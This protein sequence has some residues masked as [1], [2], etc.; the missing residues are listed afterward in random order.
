MFPFP[1]FLPMDVAQQGSVTIRAEERHRRGSDIKTF[2]SELNPILKYDVIWNGGQN[3]LVA[4]YQPRFIYTSTYDRRFPPENL[5]NRG[6]LNL[7]DPNDTPLSGYHNGGFGYEVTRQRWRLSLY[8]F[9]AYGDISTT[10]LLV[11]APWSGEGPPP[12]PFPIIPSTIGA[13]FTLLFLQTQLF[14]PVRL[15]PRTALIPG[16]T[17]N[18][19]GGAD[20]ASRGVIALTRGPGASLALDHAA[21]RR[22]RLI[23]SVAAF[24]V[25]T[26]F[27]DER[28]SIT[29]V[30]AEATQAW[31][32]YFD[33]HLTGEV[34]GGASIG[35]DRVNGFSVFSLGSM[36]L[37][38]D[39]WPTPRIPP[40]AAPYGLVGG[41]GNRL[42]LGV[43]A[44]VVPWID[45]FS[46][47]LEQRFVTSAAANYTIDRV[48]LRAG[49]SQARVINT[50]RSVAEY[51]IVLAEGSV[52]VRLSP[53]FSADGGVRLGYQ[54]FN[55]AVRFNELTQATIYAGLLWAPLPARF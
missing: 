11:Q 35:G 19:F 29:I 10:A 37:L 34:S 38:W 46:G 9:G 15:S 32:H 54:S 51:Q 3:H 41:H 2:E 44:K 45:L 28:D 27:Q 16:A 39:S 30:R 1:A 53:T 6:T 26:E 22:D 48:T 36:S 25:D 4:I 50:P 8:Q 12:D 33:N 49:L 43:V 20:R 18:A 52:R 14:V 31:R 5:V 21:T 47:D 42:Q 23:T 24:Q 40:G 17:Y 13:R 55:N 7:R